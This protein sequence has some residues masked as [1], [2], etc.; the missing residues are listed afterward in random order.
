MK[1]KR[2]WNALV[3]AL[4]ISVLLR[5]LFSEQALRLI[6][7]LV[8]NIHYALSSDNDYCI[9]IDCHYHKD[10]KYIEKMEVLKSLGLTLVDL[11]R[12]IIEAGD[13]SQIEVNTQIDIKNLLLVSSGEKTFEIIDLCMDYIEVLSPFEENVENGQDIAKLK[14]LK[15]T[16]V[17]IREEEKTI[18]EQLSKQW[19]NYPF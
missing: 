2:K 6:T 8:K 17:A 9:S 1:N 7:E 4:D 14:E 13:S 10:E 11:Q 5:T 18:D 16:L 15:A 3:A 19:K 12:F